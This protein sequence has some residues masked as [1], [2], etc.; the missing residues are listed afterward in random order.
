MMEWILVLGIILL[1]ILIGF[2]IKFIIQKFV[3]RFTKYTKTRI[4]DVVVS[5]VGKVVIWWS[6]LL[7]IYIALQFLPVS[8]PQKIIKLL[9]SS[10]L[11]LVII[12]FFWVGADTLATA[13]EEYINSISEELPTSIIRNLTKLTTITIGILMALQS[14]GISIT[15]LLTALGVGGLAVALALQ[16]TLSNLF[17]GL[18]IIISRQIRRG[19]Y[20]K[21]D[22]GEEGF[23]E[24]ITWRNT[25]IRTLPNNL[26]IIPNNKMANAIIVNFYSPETDLSVPVD[27]GVAYSSDL[28]KVER[29][30]IEVAK[31]I[32]QTVEGAKR[33][34]EPFIRYKEFGD[35]SINFT[36]I[37]RAEDYTKQFLIRHE[38][39]KR[40]KKRYDEEGIEIP[41]PQRDI[42]FRNF[43][44]MNLQP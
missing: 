27:V 26:V 41:F 17:A 16:D 25:I 22:S 39:I 11:A 40:L 9:N 6:I 23:V 32:Q 5:G 1:S 3:H 21:L 37:L 2:I 31:E 38:F 13:V 24:D 19:D 18:H 30:T 20:V 28:E 36:V 15:P 44:D 29:I 7:G 34:F 4:D 10:I 8:P 33:D 12:S 43:P 14:V 35:S 42:W